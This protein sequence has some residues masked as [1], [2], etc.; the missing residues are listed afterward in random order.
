MVAEIEND[1]VTETVRGALGAKYHLDLFVP[2][3][4]LER[5]RFTSLRG[6]RPI[7]FLENGKLLRSNSFQGVYRLDPKT[8]SELFGLILEHEMKQQLPR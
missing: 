6:S 5:W 2:P 3:D 7:K 1:G 4:V 8:A